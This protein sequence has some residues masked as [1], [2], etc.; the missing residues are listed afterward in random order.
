MLLLRR[1]RHVPAVLALAPAALVVLVVYVG[2]VLWSVYISMTNSRI[3]PNSNFVGFRQYQ[4]L[5]NNTRWEVSIENLF[6]FGVLF[7]VCAIVL[8]FLMAVL[9]DQNV[10]GESVLRS[11]YLYPYSMSF[12]VTGLVWNWVLNPTLGIQQLGRSWGF[13]NFTFD[14]IVNQELV[15]YTLVMAA[16]WHAAGLVMAIA[17]AGLRGIDEEIWKA[18]RV[19]GIPA[20]RTYLTIVIPMMGGSLAT[21]FVLLSISVVRLYDLVV[22]MTN[23]GPGLASEVPAKFIVETLFER[24]NIGLATAAST[25]MLIT[26]LAVIAPWL[27][28]QNKRTALGK[29]V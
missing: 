3:L 9:I 1:L 25:T 8:G 15:I 2:C 22:A 14:W 27:Y 26:V 5:F 23:G 17:L 24:Q 18:T 12:I 11:V 29:N 19:D 28:L 13:E 10:R 16:V 7:L 20:W 6:V 4:S 21:C